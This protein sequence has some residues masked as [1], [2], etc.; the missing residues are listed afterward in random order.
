MI[1]GQLGNDTIQGDGDIDIVNT[2]AG[3]GIGRA[4]APA[5]TAA[6]DLW[7]QPSVEATTDGDD[8]IEGGGGTD[9]VFGDLGQDDIIG[10]SSNLFSLVLDAQRPDVGDIIFGG[11]GAQVAR[12]ATRCRPARSPR[13]RTPATPT[14][15]S[16][17]TA[18]SY[19]L[20]AG[21]GAPPAWR[22]PA[23]SSASPT[24]TTAS[25]AE[26]DHPGRH[27][28]RLHDGGPD[29]R[30]DLFGGSQTQRAE[31]AARRTATS[32][33]HHGPD[34]DLGRRRGPRRVRRR[35]RLRRRRQ[36]RRV[37]RRRRRRPHRRL[38]PRLDLRRHRHRRHPRR[39]RPHLHQPQRPDRAAQRRHDREPPRPTIDTPG[40]I[41]VAIIN[42]TGKLNKA[43][44]L[45]PFALNPRVPG[46]GTDFDTSSTT[47]CGPTTSS[48]AA[49]TTTSSTAAPATTP[50]PAPRRWPQSYALAVRP[51]GAPIGIDPHRL[52]PA[53]SA[54]NVARL[55]RQPPAT[56]PST[57]ST[58]RAA[59]SRSTPTAS[60]N[61][62][63]GACTFTRP[64]RTAA[65]SG[66]STTT[67]PTG[68]YVDRRRAHRRRRRAVRRPRQRLARRRHR[69]ATRCG[70]AGATTC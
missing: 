14:R 54:R 62:A 47:R 69:Q 56:T 10:G 30:P 68:A 63:T 46:I 17:T 55:R 22:R 66:S 61:K 16:A 42:P 44:D 13:T 57:T 67:A 8:Y 52:Q 59:S 34:P 24:T 26:A 27:A 9:V 65:T 64:R 15:S 43:V 39:R 2:D 70:A 36:R 19:R 5:A 41:Q 18:T 31:H 60:L 38:G 20:V 28:A 11:A 45:T 25:T 23:A 58:T 12:N 29:R 37:R 21:S 7:V 4:W 51:D 48:S 3:N 50:S 53:V 32:P 33:T 1:F 49:G 35:H 6:G 40:S